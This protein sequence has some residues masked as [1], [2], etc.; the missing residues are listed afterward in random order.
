[1]REGIYWLV[2]AGDPRGA[3]SLGGATVARPFAVTSAPGDPCELGPR[4]AL[5]AGKPHRRWI[6]LDGFASRRGRIHQR[7]ALGL[8]IA[9]SSLLIAATL[10]LILVLGGARAPREDLTRALKDLGE[11]EAVP[12]VTRRTTAGSVAIG[13]LVALLGFALLAALLLWRGN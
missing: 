10:E 4:L 9:F 8:T 6:A 3:E 1:L 7:H 11:A 12:Q 5:L 13:I 2:V